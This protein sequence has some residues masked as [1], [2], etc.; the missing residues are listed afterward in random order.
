[1]NHEK[2]KKV[3]YCVNCHFNEPFYYLGLESDG[4]CPGHDG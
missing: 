3:S 1:M 4:V 2:A